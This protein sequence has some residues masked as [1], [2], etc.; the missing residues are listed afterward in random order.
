MSMSPFL[1]LFSPFKLGNVILK[2]RL[3]M[4]PMAL[5]YSTE[6][7]EVQQR[8]IDYYLERAGGG[9]GLIMTESN[10]ISPEG[11]SERHRLGLYSD[12]MVP[13]HR[14]LVE[15]IHRENT[16]I[17]AQLLHAGRNARAGAIGQYPVGPSAVPLLTKGQLYVGTI[18]RALTI[19]EIEQLVELHGKAARRALSAGFD[20]IL[21][22]ASNGYLLHTFLS[23]RSN[24]RTD[25]YGG[26]EEKRARLLLEVAR[27][28]REVMGPE[29]P[30]VVRVTAEEHQDG[31]YGLDFICRVAHWLEE[32]GVT[33]I[34]VSSGTHEEAEWTI[35]PPD[36]PRRIQRRERGP[37]QGGGEN[38][39][40]HGGP[41]QAAGHGRA[42]PLGG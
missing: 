2:N 24:K 36:R 28:I 34:N 9:V 3:V 6:K 32:A 27:K 41:H 11:R 5:N 10:Y 30:L 39:G 18:P 13:Q 37:G 31:G 42:D 20:G 15:A 38:R 22:H 26:S 19:P 12:H 14:K 21:I 17:F 35:P 16:P 4:A 29:I 8:Q 40:Q 33:E 25:S 1:H 7:G 23:P